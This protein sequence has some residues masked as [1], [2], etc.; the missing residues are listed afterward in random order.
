MY[1]S[2][3]LYLLQGKNNDLLIFPDSPSLSRLPLLPYQN[4]SQIPCWVNHILP[5]VYKKQEGKDYACVV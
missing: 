4:I 3:Q 5:V 1:S 2:G